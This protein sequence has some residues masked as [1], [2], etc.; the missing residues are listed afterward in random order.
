MLLCQ[1]LFPRPG[2]Q[3]WSRMLPSPWAAC[4]GEQPASL[5]ARHPWVSHEDPRPLI[6][7][8]GFSTFGWVLALSGGRRG[9]TG[10]L[11]CYSARRK[12][13]V[14]KPRWQHPC[15]VPA[16]TNVTDP[17]WHRPGPIAHPP[18]LAKPPQPAKAPSF[19]SR[20][21]GLALLWVK[22]R[23][24][25]PKCALI[26]TRWAGAGCQP[27]VWP[28]LQQQKSSSLQCVISGAIVPG[29]PPQT[30]LDPEVLG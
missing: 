5:P 1:R 8:G 18:S 26:G 12:R 6:I 14:H 23:R 11:P 7:P 24:N 16:M 29:C 27:R 19:P 10:L 9:V 30:P 13:P 4:R 20:R 15:A 3:D 28:R 17:S 25:E 21:C 22:M 2:H